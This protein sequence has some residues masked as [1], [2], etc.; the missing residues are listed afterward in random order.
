MRKNE[1][2][3]SRFFKTQ[4]YLEK[5]NKIEPTRSPKASVLARRYIN[6]KTNT[7]KLIHILFMVWRESSI[8]EIVRSS[9]RGCDTPFEKFSRPN[10][11]YYPY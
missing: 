6:A 1:T 3:N 10:A 11:K 4:D 5:M 2:T 8:N 7:I 9:F